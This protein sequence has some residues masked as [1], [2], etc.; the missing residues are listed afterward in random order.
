MCVDIWLMA[1]RV[2]YNND[3]HKTHHIY[4][5][6]AKKQFPGRKLKNYE[7]TYK[8][9]VTHEKAANLSTI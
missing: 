8:T 5:G 3:Q 9:G 1:G 7:H 6:Q 4:N 2:F